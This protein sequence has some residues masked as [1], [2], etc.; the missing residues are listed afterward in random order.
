MKRTVSQPRG[1]A[2]LLV[3]MAVGIAAVLAMSFLHSQ[4]TTTAIAG[5]LRNQ[6][7]ARTIAQTGLDTAIAYVKGHSDW[8]TAKNP[9]P[10]VT[11]QAFAGGRYSITAS[12]PTG[13][14]TD[15]T[16]DPLT[17]KSVGEYGGV[18]QTAEATL[19]P[20][21][22]T[23]VP[24]GV[25]V[26]GAVTLLGNARIDS[27]DS[28]KGPYGWSGSGSNAVVVTN[29][30]ANGAVRLTG[31]SKIY[32]QL[33]IGPQ[34]HAA[35][36]VNDTD[37]AYVTGQVTAL[38]Q[39]TSMS[40]A[41]PGIGG[42]ATDPGLPSWGAANLGSQGQT[43][44][45]HWSSLSLNGSTQITVHGTVSILVN[46]NVD[47]SG[48]TR[49]VLDSGASLKIYTQGQFKLSGGASI[50]M[51]T[52]NPSRCEV[53]SLGGQA[54]RVAGGGQMYGVV[55]APDSDVS[56][57]GGA[58]LYGLLQGRSLTLTGSAALH[59]DTH[60]TMPSDGAGGGYAVQWIDPNNTAS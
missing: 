56:I 19:T 43:T 11:D 12:D 27:F 32:G 59:Q 7:E 23:S 8:R 48:S 57:T 50:N 55:L 18:T 5:N 36:V 34:G 44:T 22:G 54:V 3:L 51:N 42:A 39:T 13:D 52:A 17:L 33:K 46:G 45:Y 38:N 30:T 58:S 31:S 21:A 35:N 15:N 41:S 10:W 20:Q 24:G 26:T 40:V 1:M 28:S 9:G 25:A 47:L 49:F 14:F 37:Q 29:S 4:D 16:T 53:V 2:M 6:A 60:T